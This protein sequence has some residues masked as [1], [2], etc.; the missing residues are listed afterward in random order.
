MSTDTYLPTGETISPMIDSRLPGCGDPCGPF[1]TGNTLAVFDPAVGGLFP[2]YSTPDSSL[3]NA[4][5][6]QNGER[7][8]FSKTGPGMGSTPVWSIMERSGAGVATLPPAIQIGNV[9][10]WQDGF[11]YM[12][13]VANPSDTPKLIVV[14][15]RENLNAS[16]VAWT[17]TPGAQVSLLQT[18]ANMQGRG[19]FMPWKPL[20]A[21]STSSS[22]SASSPGSAGGALAVGHKAVVNTTQGDKLRMRS[23]PG[24][25]FAVI[26]L[27]DK[28]TI[29]TLLEGPRSAN[30][31]TW[32]RVRAPNGAEGWVIESIDD[33]GEHIQT[34]LPA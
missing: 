21:P 23:G 24:A 28:G 26:M 4:V 30:G 33:N 29:V 8:L 3:W 13:P 5:F 34:L 1:F 14:N 27:L 15:T 2:V 9:N 11:L 31:L 32:W 18:P 20:A 10:G 17:G 6:I 7:I 25:S 16:T 22:A 12:P 19:P